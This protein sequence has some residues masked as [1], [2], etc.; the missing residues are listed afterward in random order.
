M[1]KRFLYT[2]GVTAIMQ[3]VITRKLAGETVEEGRAERLWM[4]YPLNVLFNA[5]AWTLLLTAANGVFR[6]ARGVVRKVG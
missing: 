3:F 2:L 1:R 6:L 4:L 5:L